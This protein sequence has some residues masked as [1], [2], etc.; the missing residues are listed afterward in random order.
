MPVLVGFVPTPEGRA[1]L[2]RAVLE[3]HLR[4]TS[5][6]VVNSEQGPAG[7]SSAELSAAEVSSICAELGVNEPDVDIRRFRNGY[8]PADDVLDVA[9][10]TGA[11]LIV[12]GLRRRTAVG[13]LILG[14]SAQRILL[15]ASCPVLAVKADQPSASQGDTQISASFTISV[16]GSKIAQTTQSAAS[17]RSAQETV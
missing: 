3:C 7:L 11:E 17:S 16:T 10:E 8:E 9:E 5:L 4:G 13:K 6:I 14:G 15:D 12:I 1:A 2:Q